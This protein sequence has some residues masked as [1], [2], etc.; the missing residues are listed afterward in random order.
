[1]KSDE[2][3]IRQ[4]LENDE[5]GLA[6]LIDKYAALL[7]SVI[8][9]HLYVL[10]AHQEECLNDVLLAHCWRLSNTLSIKYS[11]LII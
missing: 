7:K 6:A 3:I 4:L 10:P 2:E 11:D 5:A 1:M 8:H 9:K